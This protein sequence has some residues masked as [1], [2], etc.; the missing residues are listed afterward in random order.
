MTTTHRITTGVALALALG[1]SAAPASARTFD[2]AANGSY[3]PAATAAA[4][5]PSSPAS[6]AACG[7]VCSGGGY[8][9]TSGQP[10][11][12]TI[13]VPAVSAST[14]AYSPPTNPTIVHL[15]AGNSGFDWGDA[16]IGAAG[17]IAL[18]MVGL[19]GALVVSQRR[20][21][22]AHHTTAVTG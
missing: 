18:S 5:Q 19:G 20:T 9:S 4:A 11:N 2:L 10:T 1:I 13:Y 17:G 12:P 14:Q 16:G 3:V 7:D 21:R 22:H 8:S 6:S 15:T